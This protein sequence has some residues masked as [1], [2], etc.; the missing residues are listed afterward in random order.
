MDKLIRATFHLRQSQIQ[1]L[2]EIKKNTGC[3]VAETIRRAIDEY[4][5]DRVRV[6]YAG[7]ECSETGE[8]STDTR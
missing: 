2:E 5:R 3:P 1:T 7:G 8:D 4:V 6:S